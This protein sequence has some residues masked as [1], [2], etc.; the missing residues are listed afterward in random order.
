[1]SESR[2]TVPDF[3]VRTRVDAGPV[4]ELRT[5]LKTG[6]H[7]VVPSINDFIIKATAL[8]LREVPRANGTHRG[9]YWEL[10]ERINIGIAVAVEDGCSFPRSS[11]PIACPLAPSLGPAASSRSRAA[12][13]V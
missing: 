7:E 13:G 4:T 5:Q 8:A 3:E 6:G 10:W 1:M 9:D 2:A 11:T 12:K